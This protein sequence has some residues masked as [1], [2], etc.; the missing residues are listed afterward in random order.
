MLIEELRERWWKKVKE[1]G[2]ENA[3]VKVRRLSPAEA[4]G[5]PAPARDFPLRR[6]QEVLLQAELKSF[7]GQAFTDEPPTHYEGDLQSIYNLSLDTNRNRAIFIASANATYRYL[8]LITNTVHCRDKGPEACAK[9]AAQ[10]LTSILPSNAKLL[11]IGYQPAFTYHISKSFK[12]FRVTDMN[13]SNIGQVKDGVLIESYEANRE[14]IGWGQAVFATGTSI[15]NNTIDEIISLSRGKKL[16]FYGVTIAAAA[17]EFGFTRV[18]F[19][20]F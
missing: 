10:Y 20:S 16:I 3:I 12:N 14:A 5:K 4:I 8:G 2:L 1:N 9:E 19:E 6:G 18:C 13:S 17:Y 7:S 11:M 15:V